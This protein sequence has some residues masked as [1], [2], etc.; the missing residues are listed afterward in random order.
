MFSNGGIFVYARDDAGELSEL[1]NTTRSKLRINELA[2]HVAKSYEGVR[3]GFRAPA[4]NPDDDRDGRENEDRLDGV[5]N[6][7][8]GAIDEDFAA[9]GDEMIVTGYSIEDSETGLRLDFHQEAY[10]WSLPNIDGTIM[11]SVWVRNTGDLPISGVRLGAF[12]ENDEAAVFS[13]REFEHKTQRVASVVCRNDDGSALALMWFPVSA[14]LDGEWLTGHAPATQ[15]LEDVLLKRVRAPSAETQV[16][17]FGLFNQPVRRYKKAVAYGLS[18][19]WSRLEPGDEI[20][21]DLALVAVPAVDQL[22]NIAENSVKTYIGDG[23]HGYLPP[24]MSMTPR[25]LW[26]HYRP[27]ENGVLI[28]IEDLSD[29]PITRSRVSYFSGIEP[30]AIEER[31]NKPGMLQLVVRG[32]SAQRLLE[33]NGRVALKGRL[34]TG[35]F[36]EVILRPGTDH[37]G[38]SGQEA[39]LFWKTPGRLQQ[40]VLKAS[41]NPFR[42]STTVF[43]EIPSLIEQEDGSQI[44]TTGTLQT[45]IKIYNVTG[46]LISVLVDNAESTGMHTTQW[47]AVDDQGN[48]VASGVYYIKL[49]V[50]K[51]F[52]TKRLI[53]LK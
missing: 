20:R 14:D 13:R 53:L 2:R 6:D 4:P 22:E 24:L 35:E 27:F 50:E 39:D 36:F 47:G 45:T 28:D 48:P 44:E 5:D 15:N 18:P 30:G 51:K 43:Y 11:L 12:F 23:T 41:P 46:R 52:I 32:G 19:E 16:A 1:A 3:G 17:L 42:E 21:M 9:I 8:D 37:V 38:S 33:A 31:E 34:D 40:D 25:V 26:G 10:A 7:K 29:D 49:Q